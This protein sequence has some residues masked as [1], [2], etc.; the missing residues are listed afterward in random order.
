M[1]LPHTPTALLSKRLPTQLIV[2]G[3]GSVKV[4]GV[5]TVPTQ[6]VMALVIEKLRYVPFF[7][8]S[9]VKA[10][11]EM[12]TFCGL[13]VAPTPVLVKRNKYIPSGKLVDE[14]AIVPFVLPQVV[15]L[16]AVPTVKVGKGGSVN[17]LVV[18]LSIPVQPP[19]V[20]EKPE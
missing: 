11:P 8:F 7:K 16:T 13:T 17:V 1:F 3:T 4:L 18:V 12:V 6:V 9:R 19:V 2:G 5:A 15:G 14:K 10:L 20:T